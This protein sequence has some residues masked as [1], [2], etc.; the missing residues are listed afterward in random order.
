MSNL[1][2]RA[3]P[4]WCLRGPDCATTPDSAAW[5]SS[6]LHRIPAVEHPCVDVAVGRWQLDPA[7]PAQAARRQPAG[8]TGTAALPAGGVLLEFRL[9]DD[10]DQWPV[11]GAQAL[12]LTW[13]IP[14]LLHD[15][16][17]PRRR[18]AA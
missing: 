14:R 1:P 10:V 9:G 11:D 8:M 13:L 7:E 18:R 2:K 6:R 12:A 4:P 16:V 3:H 5:H 17:A 15:D